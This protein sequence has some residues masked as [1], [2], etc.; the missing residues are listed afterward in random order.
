MFQIHVESVSYLVER[1]HPEDCP[2]DCHAN[3]RVG[4]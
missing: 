1:D 4:A 2:E 3:Q